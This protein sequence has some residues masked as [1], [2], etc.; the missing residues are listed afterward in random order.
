MSTPKAFMERFNRTKTYKDSPHDIK[1]ANEREIYTQFLEVQLDRISK[2]IL[3]IDTFNDKIERVATQV[4][5][6]EDRLYSSNKLV[7]TLQGTFDSQVDN[8]PYLN[9][10]L[11]VTRRLPRSCWRM[12]SRRSGSEIQACLGTWRSDMYCSIL[13]SGLT[14]CRE[15]T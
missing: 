11:M 12:P 4:Q 5:S 7:K 1:S 15:A 3:K 13:R 2:A 9:L 8:P 6:L 10:C 14:G